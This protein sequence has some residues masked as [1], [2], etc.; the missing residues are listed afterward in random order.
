MTFREL[1][2]EADCTGSRLAR[3]IGVS[4]QTI[5]NWQDG[6]SAPSIADSQKIAKVLGVPLEKVADC[7]VA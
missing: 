1:L 2:K 5:S 4:R 7:F 6:K 3:A